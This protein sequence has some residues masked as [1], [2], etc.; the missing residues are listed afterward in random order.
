MVNTSK[1]QKQ[2][3]KR[4]QSVAY[5]LQH[6]NIFDMSLMFTHADLRAVRK[7]DSFHDKTEGDSR[8]DFE[9]NVRSFGESADLYA[10]KIK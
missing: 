6:D 7:D 5:D 4:L 1:S 3:N 9:G 2:L 10:V 8:I